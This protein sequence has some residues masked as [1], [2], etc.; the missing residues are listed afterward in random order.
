MRWPT[1]VIHNSWKALIKRSISI[2]SARETQWEEVPAAAR[3]RQQDS[4]FEFPA[5]DG[6]WRKCAPQWDVGTLQ[7]IRPHQMGVPFKE[8]CTEVT[9]IGWHGLGR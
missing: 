7:P 6:P 8:L 2:D 9:L 4:W 3:I 5:I 1:D